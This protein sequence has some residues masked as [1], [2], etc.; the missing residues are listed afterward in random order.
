MNVTRRVV[1]LSMWLVLSGC[2]TSGQSRE[3]H[4]GMPVR[5]APVFVTPGYTPAGAGLPEY[6]PGM[7]AP[8]AA[9]RGKDRRVLPPTR[10]LGVWAA[11]GDETRAAKA[12][13]VLPVSI[14]DVVLP[15]SPT[16][17]TATERAPT[18]R[19]AYSMNIALSMT[20]DHPAVR[21]LSPEQIKTCLAARL[22]QYCSVMM[23]TKADR[24]G[25]SS[26]ERWKATMTAAVQFAEKACLNVPESA[27]ADD[28]YKRAV[29]MWLKYTK[30]QETYE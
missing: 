16:A 4:D 25:S 14:S 19:C 11:D 15:F 24:E 3:Y 8:P 10:E 7:N 21:A 28:I 17:T 1:L 12:G 23:S 13:D 30:T 22:Y 2:A 6:M 27:T 26:A 5:A 20:G 29:P 9:P 18:K